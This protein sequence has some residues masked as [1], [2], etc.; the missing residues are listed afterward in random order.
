MFYIVL[1]DLDWQNNYIFTVTGEIVIMKSLCL[2][3]VP[4][5][6]DW[7]FDVGIFSAYLKNKIYNVTSSLSVVSWM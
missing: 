3:E 1:S 4:V 5:L 2:S 6:T 7:C